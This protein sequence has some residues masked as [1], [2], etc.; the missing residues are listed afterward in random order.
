MKKRQRL[1]ALALAILAILSL[2]ACSS[3]SKSVTSSDLTAPASVADDDVAVENFDYLEEAEA[4]DLSETVPEAQLQN[5][6]EKMIYS[7][8]ARIETLEF[9][10]SLEDLAKMLSACGG[11]VQYSDVTGADFDSIH[12]GR[13]IYRSAAYTLRIPVKDFK[14]FADGLSALGNVPYVS[15]NAENITMQYQDTEARLAARETEQSRLLE[16]L[17]R[18][19]TVE[20]IIVIESRLSELRYDIESLTS[21]IKNWDNLVSYS[22]L[23]LDIQEVALYT[24]ETPATLSYAEQLKEGFV[25]SLKSVGRFFK[26]LFKLIVT[27]LPVIVALAAVAVAVIIIV[28]AAVKKKKAKKHQKTD[29][30]KQ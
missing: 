13:R 27:S 26:N 3:N 2:T 16:L 19:E 28:K 1:S 14:S 20:D 4:Y 5:P 6:N 15:T 7:G 25:R 9:D 24:E 30:N 8:S 10:K 17:S 23:S 18:A 21:Q 22:T 29:E 12:S 11:F